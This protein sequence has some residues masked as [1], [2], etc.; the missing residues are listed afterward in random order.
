MN[1]TE[2]F[3]IE[4]NSQV[5][6][7]EIEA[8]FHG[9]YDSEQAAIE[10][11]KKLNRRLSELQALMYA[12]NKHA[13]LVVLQAMDG[14]GKDGTIRHVMEAW[15]PQ[16]CSVVGFKVPTAEEMAHDYLWRVH[17]MT[18]RQRSDHG[19]Q[20]LALRGSVDSACA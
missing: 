7:G 1:I 8:D 4:T 5:N 12:E 20:S 14:G 17:K 3:R 6:L 16:S 9:A 2:Q 18:P 11:Q 10:E 13:L 19:V 15:N